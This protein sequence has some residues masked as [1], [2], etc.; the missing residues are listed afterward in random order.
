MNH[1]N[2]MKELQIIPNVS[3]APTETITEIFDFIFIWTK[4]L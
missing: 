4:I 2:E 1:G 3:P